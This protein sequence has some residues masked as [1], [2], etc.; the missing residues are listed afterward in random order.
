MGYLLAID[1]GS[2]SSRAILFTPQ[3][4]PAG[5]AQQEF[6]QHFP[7]D[8]W[9]EHDPEDIWNSTLDVCREVLK[10]QGIGAEDVIAIGITNQRETTLVWD[11]VTGKPVYNAIVW[12]DRRTADF[13]EELREAGLEPSVTAKTGLLLDPYFSSTRP[14]ATMS[15]ISVIQP[16]PAAFELRISEMRQRPSP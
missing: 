14:K 16:S 10:T 8:G 15:T 6:Q 1:Q 5:V 3:G 2:T 7:A 11:R 4:E 13:C 12:Q 9:V